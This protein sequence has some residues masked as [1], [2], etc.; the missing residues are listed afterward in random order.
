MDKKLYITTAIAYV[1]GKPHIGNAL[2]YLY[3]DIW[4]RYQRQNGHE[5][6]FQV[7]TD[8]HGSKIVAKAAEA[9]L[10]PQTYTNLMFWKLD[11]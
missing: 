10:D 2:D 1:N 3:A 6:R 8:E 4:A 7:G 9:G 5:V 11:A